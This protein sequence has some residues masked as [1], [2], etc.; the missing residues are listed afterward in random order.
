MLPRRNALPPFWIKRKKYFLFFVLLLVQWTF[1][2]SRQWIGN[3]GCQIQG[4]CVSW[5]GSKKHDIKN[6]SVGPY[7]ST[8]KPRGIKKKP[9][10]FFFFNTS[11]NSFSVLTK[12]S[13]AITSGVKKS[14][15]R[16]ELLNSFTAANN[17]PFCLQFG[18]ILGYAHT[19]DKGFCPAVFQIDFFFFFFPA[20]VVSS[21]FLKWNDF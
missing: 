6:W 14:S 15:H 7:Q 9:P 20:I 1:F 12:K 16:Y 18:S 5:K 17:S 13:F 11:I 3:S 10:F 4:R 8:R 2:D 19:H 21:L